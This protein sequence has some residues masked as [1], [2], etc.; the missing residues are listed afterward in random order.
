MPINWSIL[1]RLV[2]GVLGAIARL[3]SDYDHRS[4][5]QLL[6]DLIALFVSPPDPPE[7]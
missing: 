7:P 3:P 4:I 6:A 5:A 2:A 1:L